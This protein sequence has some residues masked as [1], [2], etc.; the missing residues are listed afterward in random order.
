MTYDSKAEALAAQFIL[1]MGYRKARPF[2]FID[3]QLFDMSGQKFNA[4]D[5][6]IPLHPSACTIELKTTG[7]NSRKEKAKAEIALAKAQTS[8]FGNP[9][10]HIQDFSWSNSAY[11]HA[12]E[13]AKKPPLTHIVTFT[14]WPTHR[15]IKLYLKLGL[16]FCHTS[17]VA[18]LNNACALAREGFEI[19]FT[20]MTPDGQKIRFPLNSMYR[21]QCANAQDR[22]EALPATNLAWPAAIGP[23]ADWDAAGIDT[24]K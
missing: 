24:R 16:L 22:N 14:V 10:K 20:Q 6:F 12:E 21:Y 2:E 9:R 11:K 1:P 23:K 15:E 7:L 13:N 19:W 17:A 8:G 4:V 3:A 5:D 18:A